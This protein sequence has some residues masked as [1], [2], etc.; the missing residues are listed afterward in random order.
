M[1]L[2]KPAHPKRS[3]APSNTAHSVTAERGRGRAGWS[4]CFLNKSLHEIQLFGYISVF[5]FSFYK[6]RAA[7]HGKDSRQRR[8]SMWALPV[9]LSGK[10]SLESYMPRTGWLYVPDTP[11]WGGELWSRE[12]CC[13]FLHRWKEKEKGETLPK[14]NT[15]GTKAASPS[16]LL[17]EQQ[18]GKSLGT[19]F[20][21]LGTHAEK[22]WKII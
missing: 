13:V 11:L 20:L 15:E 12:L 7:C 4:E 19:S 5:F 6:I 1:Q 18:K 3:Q 2:C 10:S 21:T 17:C 22:N 16:L 9:F 8:K 14:W